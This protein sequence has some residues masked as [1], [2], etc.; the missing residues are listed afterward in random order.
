[1]TL[2]LDQVKVIEDL[3]RFISDLNGYCD[4]VAFHRNDLELAISLRAAEYRRREGQTRN[5]IGHER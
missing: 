3:H 4:V 1:M 2:T 5:G